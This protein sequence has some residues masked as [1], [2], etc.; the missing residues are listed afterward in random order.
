MVHQVF[1]V[2]PLRA[3]AFGT[4][5]RSVD[6]AGGGGEGGWGEDGRTGRDGPTDR[7]TVRQTD[8]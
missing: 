1:A 7:Q 3:D 2:F 6:W 8:R 5:R 4:E